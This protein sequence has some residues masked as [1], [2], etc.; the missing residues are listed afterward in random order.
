M[1]KPGRRRGKDCAESGAVVGVGG[2]GEE[3]S[4]RFAEIGGNGVGFCIF[5]D[6]VRDGVGA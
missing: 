5:L 3:R 4:P 2:F 1:G 6:E